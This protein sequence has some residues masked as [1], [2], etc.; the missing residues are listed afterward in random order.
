MTSNAFRWLFALLLMQSLT[1]AARA[2]DRPGTTKPAGETG[3]SAPA[4][5]FQGRIERLEVDARRITLSDVTMLRG[6]QQEKASDSVTFAIA[7]QARIWLDGREAQLR[8]LH[9]GFA[10][11]VETRLGNAPA[12]RA[13]ASSGNTKNEP[14]PTGMRVVDLIDARSR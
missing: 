11:R 1:L 4:N 6:K 8:D 14:E 13:K 10:V 5:A 12:G 7:E 3:K 2:E 9:E